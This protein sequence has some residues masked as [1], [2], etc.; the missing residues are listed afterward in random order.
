MFLDPLTL[1]CAHYGGGA[2]SP[3]SMRSCRGSSQPPTQYPSCRPR[4]TRSRAAPFP[5]QPPARGTTRALPGGRA[6]CALL[7]AG[8]LALNVVRPRF[9]CRY[10]CPLGTLMGLVSR[11]RLA[12]AVS[13]AR[14]CASLQPLRPPRARWERSMRRSIFA[15]TR[16]VHLVPGM[17]RRVLAGG[18]RP[19]PAMSACPAPAGRPNPA[20][21]F[22]PGLQGP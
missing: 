5:R 13:R 8:V 16:G 12:S 1:L 17:R 2:P 19:A 11:D 4:S 7:F 21:S 6:T 9:W 20:A 3:H 15:A 10:L 14:A 22:W 18:G